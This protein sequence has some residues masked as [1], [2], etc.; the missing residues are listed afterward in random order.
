MTDVYRMF[1]CKVLFKFFIIVYYIALGPL[2]NRSVIKFV[3]L[4]TMLV[5]LILLQAELWT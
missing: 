4:G 3:D 5:L 1:F 2:L